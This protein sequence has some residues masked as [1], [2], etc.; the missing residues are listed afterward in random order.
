MG[1]GESRPVPCP[2]VTAFYRAADPSSRATEIRGSPD[3]L[4]GITG[5]AS[6]SV[7]TEKSDESE[8]TGTCNGARSV[9][10]YISS[11]GVGP[12]LLSPETG[13]CRRHICAACFA[14]C[15][16]AFAFLLPALSTQ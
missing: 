13:P 16:F 14:L 2:R 6:L 7:T 15:L 5:K 11:A 3:G 10:R 4:L 12:L 1:L 9:K 8:T